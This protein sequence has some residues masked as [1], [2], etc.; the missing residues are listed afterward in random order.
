[1]KKE[2]TFNLE[3]PF[4]PGFY[5]SVWDLRDSESWF[6][7]NIFMETNL[8]LEEND[9]KFDFN[10]YVNDVAKLYTEGFAYYCPSIVK[11]VTFTKVVSPRFYNFTT[12]SIY[13]DVE[14]LDNWKD[15][16]K[17]FMKKNHDVVEALI[18][19]EH[20]SHS[21]YISR[22]S[23]KIDE[24]DKY[25]FVDEDKL[26]ISDMLKYMLLVECWNQVFTMDKLDTA[27]EWFDDMIQQYILEHGFDDESYFSLTESGKN[28]IKETDGNYYTE[29]FMED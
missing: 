12:D 14:F 24:W 25:L 23:N 11:S 28:K 15:V 6:L 13:A 27:T 17:T 5:C 29:K 19:K 1:M 22:M 8:E 9:Y 16:M 7:N 3:V 4:F 20:T 26:Y 2:N 21:G 18:K 10:K